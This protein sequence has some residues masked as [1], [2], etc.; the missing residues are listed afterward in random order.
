M[1]NIDLIIHK[2]KKIPPEK[3]VMIPF[4]IG[5]IPFCFYIITTIFFPVYW[6]L[7][8][9]I[10]LGIVFLSFICSGI[11]MILLKTTPIYKDQPLIAYFFGLLLISGGVYY[12][13]ISISK[14]IVQL[15]VG[16]FHIR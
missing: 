3:K 9:A 16:N 11:L 4:F 5:V 1:R 10:S 12:F 14:I 8:E 6:P 13:L 2:F 15:R 7:F